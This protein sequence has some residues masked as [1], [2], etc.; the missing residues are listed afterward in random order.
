MRHS[1]G[2]LVL[3]ARA[4]T[5]HLDVEEFP[6]RRAATVLLSTVL[7]AGGTV[8]M[9]QSSRSPL[10]RSLQQGGRL[11]AARQSARPQRRGHG[12]RALEGA[13]PA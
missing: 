4:R 1:I 11:Q 3:P 8:A 13:E 9:A 5:A 12:D 6:V 10:R 7:T 2:P